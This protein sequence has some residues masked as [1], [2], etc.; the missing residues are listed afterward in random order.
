MSLD[1]FL[2]A[3]AFNYHAALAEMQ[4]GVKRTHWMWYAFPQ[5]RGLA[6]SRTAHLYGIE[7]AEEAAAYLAHP[8]LGNRLREITAAVLACGQTDAHGIFGSPDDLKFRSCMTLFYAVSGEQLF[9]DALNQF[10]GGEPDSLTL[11]MLMS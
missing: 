4:N 8:V 11:Q 1:R 5:L 9:Q 3:Q 7:N 2:K 10:Y 6:R